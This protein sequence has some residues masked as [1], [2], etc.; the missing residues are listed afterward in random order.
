MGIQL[1]QAAI[2][3]ENSLAYREWRKRQPKTRLTPEQRA[4]LRRQIAS[5]CDLKLP[6][7]V[8]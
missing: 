2:S 4:E 3:H 8:A 6:T 7:E 5:Y 1:T